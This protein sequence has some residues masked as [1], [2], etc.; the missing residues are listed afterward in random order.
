MT[1]IVNNKDSQNNIT[2]E[3]NSRNGISK[4]AAKLK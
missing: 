4:N 2:S 1:K 3:G